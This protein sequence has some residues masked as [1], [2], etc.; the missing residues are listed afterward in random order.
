M[1]SNIFKY[2]FPCSK[3]KI[4]IKTPELLALTLQPP[5]SCTVR[6]ILSFDLADTYRRESTS[7]GM[8][9]TCETNTHVRVCKVGALGYTPS[10]NSL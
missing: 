9:H 5:R 1:T 2:P 4:Q 3:F 8:N 7:K 10:T 6:I